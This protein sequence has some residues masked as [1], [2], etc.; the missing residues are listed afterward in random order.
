V[1]EENSSA[2]EVSENES[3]KRRG[4]ASEVRENESIEKISKKLV[5]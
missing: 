1:S 3:E 4:S 2:S 5:V